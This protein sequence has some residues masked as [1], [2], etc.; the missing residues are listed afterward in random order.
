VRLLAK[1]TCRFLRKA[2]HA[3]P[4]AIEA[5][6]TDLETRDVPCLEQLGTGGA[7][8]WHGETDDRCRSGGRLNNAISLAK[9]SAVGIKIDFVV[10]LT[11]VATAR[12]IG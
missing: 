3:Q 1:V 4:S 2:G 11:E 8:G 10:T 6:T 7:L 9:C 5:Y 12:C